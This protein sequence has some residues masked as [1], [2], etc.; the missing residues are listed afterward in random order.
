MTFDSRLNGQECVEMAMVL[1][2]RLDAVIMF[3]S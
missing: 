1:V 3:V 2:T